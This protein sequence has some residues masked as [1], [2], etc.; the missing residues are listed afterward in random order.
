MFCCWFFFLLLLV[1]CFHVYATFFPLSSLRLLLL[2]VV[3]EVMMYWNRAHFGNEC[4][5]IFAWRFYFFFFLVLSAW[6]RCVLCCVLIYVLFN[7]QQ[8]KHTYTQVFVQRECIRYKR[9]N[10]SV[11]VWSSMSTQAA[12]TVHLQNT[13]W[14]LHYT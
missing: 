4:Y 1:V 14:I 12:K 9:G 3:K 8:P 6:F 5:I 13:F 11:C 7:L 10:E 2:L